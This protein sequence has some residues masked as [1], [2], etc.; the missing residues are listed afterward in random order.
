M[1]G[2]I[3]DDVLVNLD[4]YPDCRPLGPRLPQRPALCNLSAG[5]A[6]S[7]L[8]RSAEIV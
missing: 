6:L 3:H 1:A 8:A 4:D 5:F 7:W 2:H